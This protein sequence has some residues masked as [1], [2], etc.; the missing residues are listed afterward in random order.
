MNCQIYFNK[1]SINEGDNQTILIN[2][3]EYLLP[4]IRF[5]SRLAGYLAECCITELKLKTGHKQTLNI[6][7][8]RNTPDF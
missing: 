1:K 2:L 3:L 7:P 5:A 8:T 4:E 6:A